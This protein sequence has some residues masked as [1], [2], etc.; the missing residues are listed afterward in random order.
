M[1]VLSSVAVAVVG[2]Y[3]FT[4]YITKHPHALYNYL[5]QHYVARL[6]NSNKPKLFASQFSAHRGGGAEFPENSLAAFAYAASLGCQLLELDVHLTADRQVVVTHDRTTERVCHKNVDVTAV[7]FDQLPQ[8]KRELML[9]QPFAAAQQPLHY[10]HLDSGPIT[11]ADAYSMPLLSDIFTAFPHCAINIDLK[12]ADPQLMHATHELI[13][14]HQ[15]QNTVAWGA[16]S[17]ATC[18]RAYALDPS[19]PLFFSGKQVLLLHLKYYSGLLPFMP[20]RERMLDIPLITPQLYAHALSMFQHRFAN[21]TDTSNN[22]SWKLM[23]AIG[24][25]KFYQLISSR[26]ALY[27]HLHARGIN[28]CFWVLNTPEEFKQAFTLAPQA[29][30]MTDYP[31]RLH[32]YLQQHDPQQQK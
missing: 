17:D 30:I 21:T 9:S 18:K 23:L 11:V 28:T 10:K 2:W 20:L 22:S 14:L 4:H 26:S 12:D 13:V 25:M 6:T 7:R 32:D 1:T 27:T 15:R 19:V 31:T 24:V 5:P 29:G 3:S 8:M 16:G